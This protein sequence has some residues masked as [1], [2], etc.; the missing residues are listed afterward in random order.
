VRAARQVVDEHPNMGAILLECAMLPP[1]RKAVREAASLPFYEFITL[2]AYVK[3][4]SH[5][6]AYSDQNFS[7][8]IR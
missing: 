3:S 8:A 5:Q 1:Y 7:A 4:G 6:N 2:I